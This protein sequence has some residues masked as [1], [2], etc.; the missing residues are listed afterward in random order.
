[1]HAPTENKDIRVN[2]QFHDDLQRVYENTAKD[3]VIILGD[4]NA[5][6]GKEQAYSQVSGRHTLHDSSNL[7]GEMVCNFAIQN[8]III[9]STQ[10]QHKRIHKATWIAP[11]RATI[12]QI[13][14]VLINAEKRSA[15]EDVRS[16]H[17]LTCD[18]DHFLVKTVIKQK[19]ITT[20]G[21][22]TRDKKGWNTDNLINQD[23]LRQYRSNLRSH[24]SNVKVE[25]IEKEWENIKKA[26]CEAA[27][28]TIGIQQKYLRTERWDDECRSVMN[29]K[30]IARQRC[31]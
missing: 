14:H 10:Y 20:L 3:A 5:K 6:I 17:G 8:N 22:G 15:V 23:K 25:D 21:T 9:M 12:N 28:E 30:N 26:I 18:S 24:L 29:E 7:N 2:E 1:V 19:L 16:M 31:L 27:T 13:D 11:D 4:L